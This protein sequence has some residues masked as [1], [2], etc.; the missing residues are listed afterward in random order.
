MEL[1]RHT[2]YLI[3]PKDTTKELPYGLKQIP[4]KLKEV[5]STGQIKVEVQSFMYN[6][7]LEDFEVLG[8]CYKE[9]ES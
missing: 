1:D 9:K 4:V 8:K 6:I 5:L 3:A 7:R 2:T